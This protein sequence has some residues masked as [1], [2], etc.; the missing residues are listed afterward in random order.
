M[1]GRDETI[2]HLYS[3]ET[4]HANAA[5]VGTRKGLEDLRDAISEVLDSEEELDKYGMRTK[6][7][8]ATPADGERHNLD[9]HLLPRDH[10]NWN[11]LALP[12]AVNEDRRKDEDFIMPPS[13]GM[14]LTRRLDV[15]TLR[16]KS[17]AYPKDVWETFLKYHD[18]SDQ[19]K[20]DF[21]R[22]VEEVESRG[23][24]T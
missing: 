10:A 15:V 11:H 7:I 20:R 13:W 9:V 17:D 19:E 23:G 22:R 16:A 4:W 2:L 14:G 18:L 1:S 12:Y 24:A 21:K 6:R 5:I 3:Q 8:T